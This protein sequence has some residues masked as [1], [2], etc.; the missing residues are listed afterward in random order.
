MLEHK[1]SNFF[2]FSANMYQPTKHFAGKEF[3]TLYF[4][5]AVIWRMTGIF[6]IALYVDAF[7]R[8]IKRLEGSRKYRVKEK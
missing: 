1:P 8:L 7:K 2:D 4:N 6:F 5:I 3:Y